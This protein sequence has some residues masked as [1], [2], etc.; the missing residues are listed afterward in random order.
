MVTD[1]MREAAARAI[2]DVER[3]FRYTHSWERANDEWRDL[4]RARA[5]AAL[6]A[7]LPAA[8][9]AAVEAETERCA[10][11]ALE[12]ASYCSDPEEGAKYERVAAAIRARKEPAP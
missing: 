5:D 3:Q 4:C 8:I 10:N 11:V 7:V 1:E 6:A 12:I 9:Q 2:S